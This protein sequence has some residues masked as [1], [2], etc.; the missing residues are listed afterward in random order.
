M[1]LISLDPK[2][3]RKYTKDPQMLQKAYRPCALL[4]KLK[5]KGQR[6]DFAVPLRSNIAPSAPKNQYF[7]LP[8]R[9]TTKDHYRHGLH[10][11]K[12]FPV[13][14]SKVNKFN[15][16]SIYYKMLKAILDK[17]EKEI[18]RQCQDYLNSYEKGFHPKFCTDIDFLMGILK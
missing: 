4:I 5:Y 10:Y 7:P 14:R 9:K 15:T 12:M 8:P 11:I 6:L 1:R 3:L 13:D 2:E 17:H 16:D 18:I